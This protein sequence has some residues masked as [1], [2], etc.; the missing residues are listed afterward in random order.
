M[1]SVVLKNMPDI[2][3]N[4]QM[5]NDYYWLIKHFD[6]QTLDLSAVTLTKTAGKRLWI[7]S[8]NFKTKQ[9]DYT[10]QAFQPIATRPKGLQKHIGI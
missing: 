10:M 8:Y 1:Q 9:Y 2:I 7:I 5:K 6:D 3:V 4:L